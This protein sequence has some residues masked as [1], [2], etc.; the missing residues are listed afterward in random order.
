V[1]RQTNI[2]NSPICDELE[3]VTRFDNSNIYRKIYYFF[4]QEIRTF[5]MLV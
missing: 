1:S 2:F 4:S 3:Q 5:L